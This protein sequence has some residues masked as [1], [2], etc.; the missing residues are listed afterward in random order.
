MCNKQKMRRVLKR[1]KTAEQEISQLLYGAWHKWLGGKT[2]SPT[3]IKTGTS[4]RREKRLIS[5]YTYILK[6][7]FLKSLCSI[8]ACRCNTES[9]KRY[10]TYLG[11]QWE[12]R[13]MWFCPK[14]LNCHFQ[15]FTKCHKTTM[16]LLQECCFDVS[17]FQKQ[18]GPG[19]HDRTSV[20]C[21][22]RRAVLHRTV[23]S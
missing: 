14:H 4:C 21:K 13:P 5:I 15:C 1:S 16:A 12:L 23:N 22:P 17:F 10:W 20:K 9:Y 19:Q 6:S 2:W 11:S 18:K 3:S 7:C 8:Q